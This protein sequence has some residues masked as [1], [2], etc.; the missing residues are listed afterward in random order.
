MCFSG[1]IYFAGGLSAPNPEA[2]DNLYRRA[3]DMKSASG[4][5][6]LFAFPVFREIIMSVSESC[7]C[8]GCSGNLVFDIASQTLVCAH[9]GGHYTVS[10]YDLLKNGDSRNAVPASEPAADAPDAV[11]SCDSCG[12]EIMSGILGLP[13][14]V[15]SAETRWCSLTNTGSSG[16]RIS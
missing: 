3:C 2:A 9:C 14:P 13:K 6:R 5:F 12:G 16:N 4:C 15:P 10:E 11:Y 8:P 1:G 7:S